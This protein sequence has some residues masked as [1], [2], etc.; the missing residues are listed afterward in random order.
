MCVNL[1]PSCDPPDS[2]ALFILFPSVVMA[3]GMMQASRILH[4]DI[5]ARLFHNPLSF[6]DTT[7]LGRIVNRFSKDVDMIDNTLPFNIR[8]WINCLFSVGGS[9]AAG[10]WRDYLEFCRAA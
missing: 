7:P 1:T 5:L 2:T 8:S 9:G 10:G 4:S 3:Y 6:F